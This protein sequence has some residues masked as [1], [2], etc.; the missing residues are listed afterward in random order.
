MWVFAGA[1]WAKETERKSYQIIQWT[2]ML[3]GVPPSLTSWD[4]R[5]GGIDVRAA[6]R[7]ARVS[8]YPVGVGVVRVQLRRSGPKPHEH[9]CL[10]RGLVMVAVSSDP[11]G[12]DI[13]STPQRG[14]PLSPP[15]VRPS[16]L[17]NEPLGKAVSL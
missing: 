15:V 3:H 13:A 9:P 2:D 4:D 1:I 16:A 6:Y 5:E 7:G 17:M 10:G 8:K 12:N 11:P 14:R